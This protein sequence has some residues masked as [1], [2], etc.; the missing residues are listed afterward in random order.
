MY[1]QSLQKDIFKIQ[2]T[3]EAGSTHVIYRCIY[4]CMCINVTIYTHTHTHTIPAT[5]AELDVK[6]IHKYT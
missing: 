1:T 3:L 6:L 4:V 5:F 2:Y